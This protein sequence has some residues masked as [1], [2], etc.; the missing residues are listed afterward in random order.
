[1][2]NYARK[3]IK[4][5]THIKASFARKKRIVNK[6]NTRTSINLSDENRHRVVLKMLGANQRLAIQT[7]FGLD[8][9]FR[10]KSSI[11]RRQF[12]RPSAGS[13]ESHSLPQPCHIQFPIIPP[14]PRHAIVPLLVNTMT[15]N[16]GTKKII[17]SQ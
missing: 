13:H 11:N 8:S 7:C 3:P 9:R 16:N 5:Q 4:L 2:E 1:V 15:K 6:L 12:A 10:S 17:T 14:P